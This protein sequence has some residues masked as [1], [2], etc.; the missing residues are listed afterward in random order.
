MND[1][2]IVIG[3]ILASKNQKIYKKWLKDRLDIKEKCKNDTDDEKK[4]EDDTK[5]NVQCVFDFD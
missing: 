5:Y 3:E 1:I 2:E 4:I